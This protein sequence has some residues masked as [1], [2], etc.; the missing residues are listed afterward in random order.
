MHVLPWIRKA[1]GTARLLLRSEK[2]WSR[3]ETKPILIFD[4]RTGLPLLNYIDRDHASLLYLWQEQLNLYVFL[5]CLS[6]LKLSWVDYVIE[7]I[8]V[9]EPAVVVTS[10]DNSATFYTLKSSFPNIVSVSVQSSWRGGPADMFHALDSGRSS[11]ELRADFLLT[12]NQEIGEWYRKHIEA[13]IVAIGSLINNHI[14]QTE[15]IDPA[16]VAFVSEFRPFKP[17]AVAGFTAKGGRPATWE[18]VYALERLLLPFLADYCESKGLVLRVCGS[19][20]Q[21]YDL[22]F[23]FYG[24]I[25]AGKAWQWVP[26]TDWYSSYGAVNGAGLVVFMDSSLGYES[27]ARGKK[28]ACL[29]ARDNWFQDSSCWKFGWPL[30]LPESGPFWTNY[31]DLQEFRRVLDFVTSA[32]D[33]AWAETSRQVGSR[34]MEFDPGNSRF[35]SLLTRLNV[36]VRIDN[37]SVPV[38]KAIRT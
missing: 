22:E 2:V 14:K 19:K 30:A 26:R 15:V 32:S 13:E 33:R 1:F 18:D 35:V 11:A 6:R 37:E 38:R 27:L 9:V 25:L 24:A 10:S 3:P 8:R 36:P 31:A 21:N 4:A 23:A 28:V 29:S 12:Y 34:L 20:N 5:R 16:T 7:Y 17:G